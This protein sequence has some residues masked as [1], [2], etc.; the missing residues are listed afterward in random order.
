[1][2]SFIHLPTVLP[3]TAAGSP[4]TSESGISMPPGSTDFRLSAMSDIAS[5]AGGLKW[6]LIQEDAALRDR[7]H[8]HERVDEPA[9]RVMEGRRQPPDDLEAARLPQPHRP[10]V[11]ADDEIEL[12]RAEAAQRRAR[13]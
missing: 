4:S 3:A 10:I 5:G 9:R 7:T 13:E 6:Q 2:T 8:H 1:M 11:G 12:H